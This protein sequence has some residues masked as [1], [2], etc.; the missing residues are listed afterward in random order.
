MIEVNIVTNKY[1]FLM[2]EKSSSS[3]N[4]PAIKEEPMSGVDTSQDSIDGSA[5][6]RSMDTSQDSMSANMTSYQVCTQFFRYVIVVV[7]Y[8]LK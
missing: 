8:L 5:L 4:A 3:H 1:I 7:Y 2:Q 6:S